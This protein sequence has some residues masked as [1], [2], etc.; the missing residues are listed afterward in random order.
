M[1]SVFRHTAALYRTSAIR[2]MAA[3]SWA[4]SLSSAPLRI[5][6]PA[7]GFT[8]DALVG[9]E[10]KKVSLSDYAGKYV[11]L[12]FYPLDFTFVCPSEILAFEDSLSKFDALNTAVVGAS[13][14]SLYSHLAWTQSPRK[15]GVERVDRGT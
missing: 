9:D 12:F 11:V 3:A 7:P 13:V 8:A 5:G 4:S 15:V 2:K 6:G 1:F 10:F 14:D